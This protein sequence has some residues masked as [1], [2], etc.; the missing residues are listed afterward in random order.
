MHKATLGA[1]VR[2]KY[3]LLLNQVVAYFIVRIQF[4]GKDIG[5]RSA[6][7]INDGPSIGDRVVSCGVVMRPIFFAQWLVESQPRFF[8]VFAWNATQLGARMKEMIRGFP[9]ET[10][11]P[12]VDHDL[13][14]FN[15]STPPALG[16]R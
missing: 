2:Q 6:Q 3:G 9:T 4:L 5:S 7:T 16:A 11:R 14:F 10:T 13:V 8:A 1:T 12:S 15:E